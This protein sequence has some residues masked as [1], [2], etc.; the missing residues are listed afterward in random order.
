[1][2]TLIHNDL[3][4]GDT[5]YDAGECSKTKLLTS[6]P[7]RKSEKEGTEGCLLEPPYRAHV[8]KS[9]LSALLASPWGPSL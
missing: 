2:V 6:W 7:E 8:L 3:S 1:M 5:A 9:S 4:V